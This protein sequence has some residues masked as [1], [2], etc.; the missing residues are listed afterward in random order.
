MDGPLSRTVAAHAVTSTFSDDLAVG[1]ALALRQKV[2]VP[3]AI[4]MG[5][6]IW[7]FASLAH[8]TDVDALSSGFVHRVERLGFGVDARDRRLTRETPL[9]IGV[10]NVRDVFV[11]AVD[12]ADLQ[13]LE[14]VE[15]QLNSRRKSGKGAKNVA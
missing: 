7:G 13:E 12:R 2:V 8:D 1:T 10:P 15:K 4:C 14:Q 11:L 9:V 5:A 6:Q 3:F